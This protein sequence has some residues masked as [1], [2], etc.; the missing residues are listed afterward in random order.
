MW[1][2]MTRAL[3]LT[4]M[5]YIQKFMLPEDRSIMTGGEK[6]EIK[7]LEELCINH[8]LKNDEE[9]YYNAIMKDL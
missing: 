8:F 9:S 5:T 6:A 1:L 7:F 2:E 3:K 4:V